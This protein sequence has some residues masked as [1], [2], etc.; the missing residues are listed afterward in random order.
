V[1]AR[2]QLQAALLTALRRLEAVVEDASPLAAASA[3]EAASGAASLLS[4][5]KAEGAAHPA[6]EELLQLMQR[7][8]ILM[9][10]LSR[11]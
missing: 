2:D 6:L 8:A 5:N 7:A 9:R 11:R 4:R 1:S 10:S 3:L